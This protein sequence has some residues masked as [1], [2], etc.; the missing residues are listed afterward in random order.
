VT[1]IPPEDWTQ[2]PKGTVNRDTMTRRL[3]NGAFSLD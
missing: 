3:R 2:R 1:V